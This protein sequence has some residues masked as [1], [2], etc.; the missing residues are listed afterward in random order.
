MTVSGIVD[1]RSNQLK[2]FI[3]HV[4]VW[5]G[6]PGPKL[7]EKSIGDPGTQKCV[8]VVS[9]ATFWLRFAVSK[10]SFGCDED[11]DSRT[12]ADFGKLDRWL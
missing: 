8:H 12:L 6:T 11:P 7:D 10:T 4:F 5:M 3:F 9:R 1:R 2:I